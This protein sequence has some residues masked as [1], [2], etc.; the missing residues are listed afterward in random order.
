M[1]LE[2][3]SDWIVLEPFTSEVKPASRLRNGPGERIVRFSVVRSSSVT[4]VRAFGFVSALGS[5]NTST[6][7]LPFARKVERSARSPCSAI[8]R[9]D[10]AELPLSRRI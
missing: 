2:S 7:F 10:S 4:S 3:F 1:I 9:R 8:M 5:E 6:Q